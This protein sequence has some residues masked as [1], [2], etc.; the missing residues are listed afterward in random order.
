MYYCIYYYIHE[1][2]HSHNLIVVWAEAE[3][4]LIIYTCGYIYLLLVLALFSLCPT[5]SYVLGNRHI[6]TSNILHVLMWQLYSS[7]AG[8]AGLVLNFHRTQKLMLHRLTTDIINGICMV[9]DV[10]PESMTS[11]SFSGSRP[12]SSIDSAARASPSSSPSR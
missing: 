9:H 1:H 6:R 7:S 10:V 4:I 2:T 3:N 8:G 12:R 11:V 5:S